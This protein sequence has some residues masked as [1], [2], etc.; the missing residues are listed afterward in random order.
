LDALLAAKV[1]AEAA[2]RHPAVGIPHDE[3]ERFA[4]WAG[5]RLPTEAEWEYAARSRGRDD[6]P[7]VWGKEPKPEIGTI[8]ANLDSRDRGE[9]RTTEAK[10]FKEDR[11]LQGVYDLTGNVREWCADESKDTKPDKGQPKRFIV[12]GGSWKSVAEA[13]A[14]T[15]HEDAAENERLND[16]GFRIVVDPP[17]REN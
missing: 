9:P 11:T 13:F 12:R 15:V 16:L 8:Q 14:T 2:L 6:R 5:G 7:Y 1:S 4:H 10:Y 17:R 3:A